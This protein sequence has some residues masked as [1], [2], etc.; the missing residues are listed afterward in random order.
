MVKVRIRC[1]NEVRRKVPGNHFCVSECLVKMP[2]LFTAQDCLKTGVY[3][4]Y[5]L[6]FLLVDNIRK[7]K[8]LLLL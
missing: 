4:K 3:L 7:Q 6:V 1:V 2:E 5:I 8:G